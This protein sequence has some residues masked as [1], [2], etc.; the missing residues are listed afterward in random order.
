MQAI[1]C[2]NPH[3]ARRPGAIRGAPCCS[4]APSLVSILTRPEDR[5]LH[6]MTVVR[7]ATAQGFNP[8]PARRPGAIPPPSSSLRSFTMFQSSPGPKTGCFTTAASPMYRMRQE[9]QSSPGPKTG[10]FRS[11]RLEVT[12]GHQCFNPH[13]ARRPGA[14]GT[15]ILMSTGRY[16][17]SIL[18]RPEDRVLRRSVQATPCLDGCFNPHPA[19]RPGASRMRRCSCAGVLSCFNPHPARR[20]GASQLLQ[21]LSGAYCR[22]VSILTRPEDRVLP[23]PFQAGF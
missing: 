22:V 14:S 11:H 15:S 1:S 16:N 12:A 6:G 5:V 21:L 19:R 3:P 7:Q 17:V 23:R 9:F 10:C 8:H 13:P 20:P 4:D 2:F 18:T